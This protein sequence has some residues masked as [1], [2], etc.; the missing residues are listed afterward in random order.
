MAPQGTS[1]HSSKLLDCTGYRRHSLAHG[2]VR[3]PRSQCTSVSCNRHVP[4]PV[5]SCNSDGP[6]LSSLMAP[7]IRRRGQTSRD[8]PHN[9]HE[10]SAR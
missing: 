3:V 6:L 8:R 4:Y 10:D 2:A 1:T 5:V 9:I 7:E